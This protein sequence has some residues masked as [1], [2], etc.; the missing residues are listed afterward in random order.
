MAHRPERLA[1]VEVEVKLQLASME[2]VQVKNSKWVLVLTLGLSPQGVVVAPAVV[3]KSRC[4]WDFRV[5]AVAN[6]QVLTQFSRHLRWRRRFCAD[7][8]PNRP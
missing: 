5:N 3:R 2:N 8:F 1:A 4:R 7:E 6:Q